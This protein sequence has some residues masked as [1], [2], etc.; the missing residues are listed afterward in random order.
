MAFSQVSFTDLVEQLPANSSEITSVLVESAGVPPAIGTTEFFLH[1]EMDGNQLTLSIVQKQ[2]RKE[3][4]PKKFIATLST[5]SLMPV[6]QECSLTRYP[7]VKD[8]F[9][10]SNS[11]T[12]V[13]FEE[14]VAKTKTLAASMAKSGAAPTMRGVSSASPDRAGKKPPARQA[15]PATNGSRADTEGGS[16]PSDAD[17]AA[18]VDVARALFTDRNPRSSVLV[19][20]PS[21]PKGL[22]PAGDTAIERI[23]N[24]LARIFRLHTTGEVSSVLG[25]FIQLPDATTGQGISEENLQR[26]LAPAL[27]ELSV[28]LVVQRISRMDPDTFENFRQELV[29]AMEADNSRFL[30]Y[31]NSLSVDASTLAKA[32]YGYMNTPG[33]HGFDSVEGRALAEFF[34]INALMTATAAG[35]F[36]AI[37]QYLN[38]DPSRPDAGRE[39]RI[40]FRHQNMESGLARHYQ[41]THV[42][43][44]PIADGT[45]LGDNE[46]L[47][48]VFG[49]GL[50]EIYAQHLKF[51]RADAVFLLD[52]DGIDAEVVHV[53]EEAEAPP[54]TR[55]STTSMLS[56]LVA[57]A[58][59][60]GSHKPS[61]P[62]APRRG[63]DA[64]SQYRVAGNPESAR[65]L[66][67]RAVEEAKAGG[68]GAAAS[69][70]QPRPP[71][72]PQAGSRLLSVVPEG[73]A[74]PTRSAGGAS[75]SAVSLA[76]QSPQW[77]AAMRTLTLALQSAGEDTDAISAATTKF[78]SA[79][80]VRVRP[81]N[82]ALLMGEDFARMLEGLEATHKL[83]P[84]ISSAVDALYLS[85]LQD[86][87]EW[88]VKGAGTLNPMAIAAVAGKP[89]ASDVRRVPS[90]STNPL[91]RMPSARTVAA[92]A[93][94][95]PG[96][97]SPL[98]TAGVASQPLGL[99]PLIKAGVSGAAASL[100]A[101]EGGGV[102]E[103]KDLFSSNPLVGAGS[104]SRNDYETTLLSGLPL[105][106]GEK[107]ALADLIQKERS[108]AEKQNGPEDAKRY[109]AEA[110][111]KILLSATYI[112]PSR[113]AENLK[114]RRA[115]L[116]AIAKIIKD[117]PDPSKV[118]SKAKVN[119]TEVL[120]HQIGVLRQSYN[121]RLMPLM[122]GA[123]Q[124]VMQGH[125]NPAGAKAARRGSNA[126][127]KR[128]ASR[129]S[130]P[131]GAG[132]ARTNP[133]HTMGE[134]GGSEP[135][136]G[137]EASAPSAVRSNPLQSIK[138]AQP[139]KSKVISVSSQLEKM[140]TAGLSGASAKDVLPSDEFLDL[141]RAEPL[142]DGGGQYRR[143]LSALNTYVQN[144]PNVDLE[145]AEDFEEAALELYA[146]EKGIDSE[147]LYPEEGHPSTWQQALLH[148]DP[149]EDEHLD[150]IEILIK[151]LG[152][153]QKQKKKNFEESLMCYALFVPPGGGDLLIRRDNLRRIFERAKEIDSSEVGKPWTI[154]SANFIKE[155]ISDEAAF[156]TPEPIDVKAQ[157]NAAAA[158]KPAFSLQD[159]FNIII[160]AE[161]IMPKTIY[162]DAEKAINDLWWLSIRAKDID[163]P[164]FRALER[165]EPKALKSDKTV[166]VGTSNPL[167]K[168]RPVHFQEY[169][170]YFSAL[171]FVETYKAQRA[172]DKPM[173]GY[174]G[175]QRKLW[176]EA[177]GLKRLC[178]PAL[179]KETV[180][181]GGEIGKTE[182]TTLTRLERTLITAP[183]ASAKATRSRAQNPGS[184]RRM[185]S[186]SGQ[187]LELAT[188]RVPSSG[189][190]SA[191]GLATLSETASFAPASLTRSGSSASLATTASL[192]GSARRM[193]GY[194]ATEP[195]HPEAMPGHRAQPQD[196][197][198]RGV[199]MKPGVSE[200]ILRALRGVFTAFEGAVRS[201]AQGENAECLVVEAFIARHMNRVFADPKIGRL[202]DQEDYL[203]AREIEGEVRKFCAAKAM[204][205]T[206]TASSP[207]EIE[208]INTEAEGYLQAAKLAFQAF[209]D[210]KAVTEVIADIEPEVMHTLITRRSKYALALRITQGV[211]LGAG[212]FGFYMAAA[213]RE[214]LWP[215]EKGD[216]PTGGGAGLPN[217]MDA[218]INQDN[219]LI[220]TLVPGTTYP[221]GTEFRFPATGGAQLD[222]NATLQPGLSWIMDG[223]TKVGVRV[224]STGISSVSI[225]TNYNTTGT[226][227]VFY[228][229]DS[230]LVPVSFSE[231]DP[232]DPD[233]GLNPPSTLVVSAGEGYFPADTIV[234]FPTGVSIIA[235][236]SPP[237][238]CT[239]YPDST[240]PTGVIISPGSNV[241]TINFTYTG[242]ASGSGTIIYPDNTYERYDFNAIIP[243]G[244][245][246][247]LSGQTLT[248]SLQG[249]SYFPMGT[250]INEPSNGLVQFNGN[251]TTLPPGVIWVYDYEN[252]LQIVGV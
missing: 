42:G 20:I 19:P 173:R 241:N 132:S 59:G 73:G 2:N 230:A 35:E 219:H 80:P 44:T 187:A 190:I 149:L 248:V 170:D 11:N 118:F 107:I 33:I 32:Y 122:T 13:G 252:P 208:K 9:T 136:A 96:S 108:E 198:G 206:M 172:I 101:P 55:T 251:G 64:A 93:D 135:E 246:S 112:P 25:S 193:P 226:I 161:V 81:D 177:E 75:S 234:S 87:P 76:G 84:E 66:L 99:N 155:I 250:I 152:S 207:S 85:L 140:R 79:V 216:V 67:E 110:L 239:W 165:T 142:R 17:T 18:G 200:N 71:I 242:N 146:R 199:V 36:G 210:G 27:R 169:A 175:G 38:A 88:K 126:A 127:L 158:R 209:M 205:K 111:K 15:T 60:A 97:V 91:A 192:L 185:L 4:I 143:R 166:A 3:Y 247:Q 244:I 46:C 179:D 53:T 40:E 26:K 24:F 211:A 245:A 237:T 117:L 213:Y 69:A 212:I 115:N 141:V 78:S 222:P 168:P 62:T 203:L 14:T 184:S 167:A 176:L 144:A 236:G 105:T 6:A 37:P 191:P 49:Q 119:P 34:G 98:V 133:L 114:V 231:F 68:T 95:L 227:N 228:P 104:A 8:D 186:G 30:P 5:E 52:M 162:D 1:V 50:T 201:K 10:H 16:P 214:H 29:T 232:P 183:S 45:T 229:G 58:T 39:Y 43:E 83:T 120:K 90:I 243:S 92:P 51:S 204:A 196:P 150:Q 7:K 103:T 63:R 130:T 181:A 180:D 217:I 94:G 225:A 223:E 163:S 54:E 86:T 72:R 145:A 178:K 128:H 182:S 233:G 240:N 138:V 224:S 159:Y 116:D 195:A 100:G 47:F 194:G 188:R 41:L 70:L 171:V 28:R 109:F 57:W 151:R 48:N 12:L 89:R 235:S 56:G 215:F 21:I 218:G 157:K 249:T 102:A 197:G 153:M 124:T 220:L 238:G 202:E 174:D 147:G 121:D 154:K 139:V 65:S 137:G 129:E 23:E 160:P 189:S 31:I 131:S 74:M 148:G 77:T 134:E 221:V 61:P 156:Y 113:K 164:M 125:F 106:G 123:A 82:P 22:I